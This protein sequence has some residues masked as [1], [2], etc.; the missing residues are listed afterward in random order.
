MTGRSVEL[1]ELSDDMARS[2]EEILS[3]EQLMELEANGWVIVHREPTEEMA[4]AFLGSSFA[5]QVPFTEGYH[6]VIA[7]SIR[8]R[9]QRMRRPD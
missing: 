8:I 4:R 1:R 9:T 2:V 7:A 6:R 3:R 5:K